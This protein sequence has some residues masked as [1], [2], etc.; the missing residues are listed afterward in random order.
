MR[1]HANLAF[2]GARPSVRELVGRIR[3]LKSADC[4]ENFADGMEELKISPEPLS[5]RKFANPCLR[6]GASLWSRE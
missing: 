3:G 5:R 1:E 4:K 6:R 2:H